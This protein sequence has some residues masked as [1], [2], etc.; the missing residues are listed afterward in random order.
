MFKFKLFEIRLQPSRIIVNFFNFQFS[1]VIYFTRLPHFHAN[2][3]NR[4]RTM[5]SIK[6]VSNWTSRMKKINVRAED[7]H[8]RDKKNI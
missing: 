6:F 4:T 3:S 7:T 2:N 1:I 5:L 8:P